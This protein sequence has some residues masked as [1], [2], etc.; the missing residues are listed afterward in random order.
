MTEEIK[1]KV[2]VTPTRKIFYVEVGDVPVEELK[3]FIETFKE[4]QK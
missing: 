2:K 4:N 1:V 3:K